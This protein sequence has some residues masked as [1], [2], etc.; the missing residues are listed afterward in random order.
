MNITVLSFRIQSIVSPGSVICAV[1][2]SLYILRGDHNP[3]EVAMFPLFFAVFATF[4][5]EVRSGISD[6]PAAI[7]GTYNTT[8]VIAGVPESVITLVCS[9]DLKLFVVY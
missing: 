5:L 2:R 4:L 3:V 7:T 9:L 8:F 6:L 1:P